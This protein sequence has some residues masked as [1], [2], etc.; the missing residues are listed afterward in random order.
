MRERLTAAAARILL[1]ETKLRTP[2]VTGRLR[3]G[4][5]LTKD[6]IKNDVP[7]APYVE[8][9]RAML[10][11]GCDAT[12]EKLSPLVLRELSRAVTKSLKKG[13]WRA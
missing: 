3:A 2:V 6:G 5:A 4:W 10:A 11:R 1:E 13:R 8:A 7:Y 12:M 9:R